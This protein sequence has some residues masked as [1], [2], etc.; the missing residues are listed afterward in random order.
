MFEKCLGVGTSMI[1]IKPRG[2]YRH[3]SIMPVPGTGMIHAHRISG[4]GD[5]HE[6]SGVQDM[7]S[8]CLALK[9]NTLWIATWTS[10]RR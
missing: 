3:D 2:G 5:R 9:T 4:G 7:M 10:M 8:M 1:Q 6:P